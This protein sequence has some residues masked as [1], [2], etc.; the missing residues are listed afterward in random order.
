[1]AKEAGI[2][3]CTAKVIMRIFREEGRVEK[4]SKNFQKNVLMFFFKYILNDSLA[5]K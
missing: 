3:Y 5:Y 1:M 2:N 4:K